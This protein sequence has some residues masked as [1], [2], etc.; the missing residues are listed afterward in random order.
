MKKFTTKESVII[1]KKIKLLHEKCPNR[2]ILR[3]GDQ[4]WPPISC[5]LTLCDFFLWEFV[6]SNV[7]TNKPWTIPELKSEI[8]RVIGEIEPPICENMIKKFAKRSIVYKQSLGGHLSDI[9][10][11]K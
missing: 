7:Y 6:K 11:H 2:V 8:K 9:A 5:E 10:F 4:D 3:K 1:V